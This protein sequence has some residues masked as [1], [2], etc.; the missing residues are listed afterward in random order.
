MI[1]SSSGMNAAFRIDGGKV[2]SSVESHAIN[3]E[4]VYTAFDVLVRVKVK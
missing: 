2:K 1:E 4:F 3:I